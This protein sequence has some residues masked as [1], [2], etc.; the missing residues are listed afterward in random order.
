MFMKQQR[1]ADILRA[2]LTW[3]RLHGVYCWR[4]NQGASRGEYQGKRRFLRFASVPGISDIVGVVADG[5]GRILCVETKRPGQ[6]LTP[7]QHAFLDVVRS[8]GGIALVVHS[9]A[10]LEQALAGVL[11]GTPATA[12]RAAPPATGADEPPW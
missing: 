10:E 4:Q 5:T 12:A 11:A 8:H 3:L 9:V 7:Y 6:S 2:C 1:E